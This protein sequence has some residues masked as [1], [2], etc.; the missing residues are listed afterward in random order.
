MISIVVSSHL[1]DNEDELFKKHILSTI[2]LKPS[3][4]DIHIY[5]NYKQYSLSEV[6]NKGLKDSIFDKVLFCHN[7]I[8][9]N[10]QNWGKRLLSNFEN[11][12]KYGILGLAGTTDLSP[13]SQ[14]MWWHHSERMIGQVSHS[15][16]GRT[17]ESKYSSNFGDTILDVVCIDGLF[18]AVDKTKLKKGFNQA[19]EGFHFYDIPF[20]CDNFLEGVNIG[21]IF[22]IKLTH[23]SIGMVN[24]EWHANRQKFAFKYWNEL[25]E[26]KFILKPD[27]LFTKEVKVNIKKTPKVAII[28]PNKSNNKMLFDCINS[29]IENNKY[30]NYTFFIADTGSNEDELSEI[31]SFLKENN[32]QS[33]LI[34]Y[35]YYNYAKINNDVVKNHITDEYELLLFCNNDIKL[36]NNVLDQ[37]VQ[38]YNSNPHVGT[39]GAR[40]HY[41]DNSIQ[42]SGIL[43]FIKNGFNNNQP[44]LTHH[45]SRSYYNYYNKNTNV[46]GN[47][48]SLM[49]INKTL[50]KTL[51]M[52]NEEYN[53][54]Y[55]E[56]FENV[57]LNLKCIIFKKNNI[58]LS[59]AVAYNYESMTRNEDSNEKQNNPKIVNF[60]LTNFNKLSTYIKQVN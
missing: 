19:F 39:I 37:M 56:C 60:I 10:T 8:I 50:F 9:F 15:H 27:I 33:K 5:K 41:T 46:I 12:P 6:Y 14:G 35:N 7:D 52:F 40:L 3:M 38:E 32:V 44:V 58:F 4:V 31:E 2:G 57:E 13:E 22:N 18:M 55:N 29:F 59:N 34:K 24:D 28:I 36:L 23:K 51:N 11:N 30:T 45:G 48:A 25:S 20:C 53:E 43:C 1:S 47:T 42:H 26:N 16:N 17:T 21:V 54:E 49:M